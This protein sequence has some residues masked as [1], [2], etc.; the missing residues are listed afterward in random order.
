MTILQR[1]FIMCVIA[2]IDENCGMD[3]IKR[4]PAGGEKAGK[5]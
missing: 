4:G 2:I 1:Y 5:W 3:L